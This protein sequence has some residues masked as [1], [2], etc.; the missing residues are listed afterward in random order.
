[1][2]QRQVGALGGSHVCKG[3]LSTAHACSQQVVSTSAAK[4]Q[5]LAEY[6]P[7]FFPVHCFFSM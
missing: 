6:R 3:G 1:M 7:E 2:Q 4:Q 5:Q